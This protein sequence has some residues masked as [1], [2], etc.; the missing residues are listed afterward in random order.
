M[1]IALTTSNFEQL[2]TNTHELP[3]HQFNHQ[4]AD[5]DPRL[6]LAHA[7]LEAQRSL[8]AALQQQLQQL[9]AGSSGNTF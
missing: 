5:G 1:L 8:S 9:L 7:A 3:T 4:V 2:P 6:R